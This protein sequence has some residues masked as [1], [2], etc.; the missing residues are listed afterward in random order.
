ML[1]FKLKKKELE[2]IEKNRARISGH[3]V[4][5]IDSAILGIFS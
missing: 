2:F 4:K 5:K 1:K 3:T